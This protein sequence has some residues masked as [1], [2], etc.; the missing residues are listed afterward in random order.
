MRRPVNLMIE[1]IVQ[2]PRV[3]SRAEWRAARGALLEVEWSASRACHTLADMRRR[4][5]IVRVE[6]DLVLHGPG[7][8]VSLVDLFDGLPRLCV[9]HIGWISGWDEGCPA[10]C[11]V[12]DLTV[13]N[14][15]FGARLRRR[16]V[17]FAAV[18]D[19]PFPKL[20]S[21]R[22][23]MRWGFPWYSSPDGLLHRYVR[24]TPDA[25]RPTVPVDDR[26]NEPSAGPTRYGDHL[27]VSRTGIS[28]FLRDADEVFHAYTTDDRDVELILSLLHLLDLPPAEHR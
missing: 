18:S 3:V 16:G 28:L 12:V 27:H 8:E 4:H 23:R 2:F 7:G 26:S 5:P 11:E 25:V 17:A 21:F 13:G 10:C 24:E 6:Q 19:A 22:D 1:R 9:Q 20:A 14:S 15:S